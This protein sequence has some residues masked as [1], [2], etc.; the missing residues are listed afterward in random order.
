MDNMKRYLE[1]AE[2][3]APEKVAQNI[4]AFYE[5]LGALREKH[6][7]AECLCA[8]ICYTDEG[9]G[10]TGQTSSVINYGD[11][12]KGVLLAA[13]VHGYTKAQFESKIGKAVARGVK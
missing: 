1:L 4:E 13:S 7:I 8:V 11:E 12:L 6:H 3:I 9:G 2:P 10:A 5:E